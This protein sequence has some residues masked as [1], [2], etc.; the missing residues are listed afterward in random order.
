[1]DAKR[2]SQTQVLLYYSYVKYVGCVC[3]CVCD[4]CGMGVLQYMCIYVVGVWFACWVY[5][6]Y[7]YVDCTCV[8]I[9]VVFFDDECVSF[10]VS[11]WFVQYV[12]VMNIVCVCVVVCRELRP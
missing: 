5:M 3:M 2:E 12:Y 1:M 7:V 10:G 6:C 8:C 4:L 9:Y 11:A